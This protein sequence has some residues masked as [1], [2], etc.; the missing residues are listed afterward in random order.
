MVRDLIAQLSQRH[1]APGPSGPAIVAACV[2]GEGHELG[3][4][5]ICGLLR[6]AG[7]PV[8]YLGADVSPRFLLEAARLHHPA[9]V[10]LSAKLERRFGDVESAINVLTANLPTE[11]RPAIIVGGS[12]AASHEAEL[13]ALGAIPVVASRPDEALQAVLALLASRVPQEPDARR[14]DS[15][16]PPPP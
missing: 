14:R 16:E 11:Q 12:L 9:A 10:L 6:G 1:A 5:M 3:L 2:E 13:R 8:Y 7:R 4:R 15:Q